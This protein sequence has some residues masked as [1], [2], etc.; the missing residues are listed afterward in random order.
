MSNLSDYQNVVAQRE[1]MAKR[2][3]DRK[4]RNERISKGPNKEN[5]KMNRILRSRGSNTVV[6]SGS[7]K[8]SPG[9]DF[10]N[11]W[12][13]G[14]T[15]ITEDGPDGGNTRELGSNMKDAI[16]KMSDKVLAD[17]IGMDGGHG[18]IASKAKSFAAKELARRN[19]G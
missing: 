6:T 12:I 15:R 8:P 14:E 4:V 16:L 13:R 1:Q 3:A 2:D 11:P 19:D 7:P 9:S 5:K 18:S 10:F 17:I